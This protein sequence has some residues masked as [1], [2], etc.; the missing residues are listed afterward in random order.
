MLGCQFYSPLIVHCQCK[1]QK[2]KKGKL[3]LGI[4]MKRAISQKPLQGSLGHPCFPGIH[5][6]H[7]GELGT[8]LS[9]GVSTI[10]LDSFS[11]F[12]HKLRL[13]SHGHFYS[14]TISFLSSH[15][16][17]KTS[18]I[19]KLFDLPVFKKH[20]KLGA[21]STCFHSKSRITECYI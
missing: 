1:C 6:S 8:Q 21:F 10:G 9:L 11:E 5:E 18:L 15:S 14:K 2:S 20:E 13:P 12:N 17:V 7:F 4:T 16:R 3:H 19:L